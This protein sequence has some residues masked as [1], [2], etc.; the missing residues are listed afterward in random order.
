VT[1][2]TARWTAALTASAVAL[3]CAPAT[4]LANSA[5]I[6]YFRNR[7]DRTAVPVLLT[8]DERTYYKDLFAAIE[9]Q[10]W[11][12]V[13]TLFAQKPDGP[14]HQV[15][16]A[17]YFLDAKSPKI[18]LDS[19]N[20]WLAKGTALPEAEQIAALAAKRG[21]VAQ[22][23]LPLAQPLVSTPTSPKRIRPRDTADGTMPGSVA[24]A[25][26]DKIKADDPASAKL[27]LD[28][29]DGGLSLPARAEWRAKIGWAFYI[30]ND[31]A[32]A[33]ALAQTAADGYGPWVAEGWWTAG[34]A[35]WRMDDCQGAVDAFTRTAAA[36]DNAELK[37]AAYYWQ[38]R[39]LVRCRQPEKAN[40]PLKLAA[41]RDETFYGMLAAEQ[42][43]LKLPDNHSGADFTQADWQKLRD[44]DT[45]R[46]AVELAEIGEDGLA[47]EVLRYQARIGGAVLYQPL[48]RLARD[49]GLPSTQLWMAYNAPVGAAPMPA[50][51]FP[52]PKWTPANGWKV[53]PALVYAHT[54]QESIFRTSVTSPAG[55]RG[56][57]Q[58]MPAT[59]R[60]RAAELGVSPADI[61]RPEVNLA[62]G[63]QHLQ[64]LRNAPGTQGL[65]PKVI[66]AYNAGL[67]PV[68]RWNT[69]IRD[70]G[71]PLLWIESV[72]YWETRGYV[73]IVLKNY[74]M[75]ERQAGGPSESRIALAQAM[76]PT[77]PDLTG[78]KAVRVAANGAILRGR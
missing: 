26:Q 7:A 48:S 34:L 72:P 58:I 8:Q 55:A 9:H 54:L 37:S 59:A 27:L 3:G 18:G 43:G 2:W 75:Y 25:I 44:S 63:Q 56:L 14:L 61:T 21:G 5:A 66:A 35:A 57:M 45:V 47:D 67:L 16:R 19:L 70:K 77:F 60:D 73:N 24:A 28:G 36:A 1:G 52:T 74:W 71:D 64:L 23:G 10:D 46:T 6:E 53:D 17:E 22:P 12:K 15:A 41:A 39:A 51:R 13:Q 29:I 65:L 11:A 33:Y 76:W 49:L 68:T 50:A 20:Q 69:E 78:S 40:D 62:F 30:E 4:A 32:T 42:L 38:S 31:D